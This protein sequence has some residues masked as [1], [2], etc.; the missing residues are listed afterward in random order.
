M[1]LR[2]AGSRVS[3]ALGLHDY[4]RAPLTPGSA[5]ARLLDRMQRREPRF[6]ELARSRIF[7]HPDSPYLDLLKHAGCAYEDLEHSVRRSGLERVLEQLRDAGVRL[8]LDE[9]KSRAPVRRAGLERAT[10]ETDFDNPV[11]SRGA[12]A[13]STSGS[14]SAGTRVLY[15][16]EFLAEEADNELLLLEAHGL[17]DAPGAYWMP[18]LPSISGIHNLLIQLRFRK[19]PR[20]WFS[21]VRSGLADRM[22]MEFVAFSCALAGLRAPRASFAGADGAGEV[23]DWMRR[24]L[25]EHGRCYLKAFTSSAVRVAR[26]AAERGLDLRGAVFLTGGEPLTARRHEF[27][28]AG[29]ARAYARY[30]STET[31]LIAAACPSGDPPDS[32]HLYEDRLAAIAGGEPAGVPGARSL[33]YTTLST[34]TGKILLNTELGDFGTLERRPCDCAFGAAGMRL[35]IHGVG[36]RD[37]L[38]GEGMSLLGADLAAIV[39]DLVARAGGGPDDF[40]FREEAGPEGLVRIA[41]VVSPAV[42]GLEDAAFVPAVLAELHRRKSGQRVVSEFWR[43]ADTLRLVRETPD[44][45]AGGKL[46]RLVSRPGRRPGRP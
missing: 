2:Q 19:P 6:L 30:V 22:A 24:A 7:D 40:Q 21:Q 45:S 12:V 41:I 35:H 11:P 9:F 34:A 15:D 27:L 38:T 43:Q 4:L 8:S 46:L 10:R 5:R 42:P 44:I 25:A 37:K 39:A 31:G 33:L 20:A 13:G 16:W 28:Q 26:A 3:L 36:S 32:M 18:A 1:N 23:A 29:G 14:R 17:L